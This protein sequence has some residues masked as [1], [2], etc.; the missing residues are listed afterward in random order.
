[1]YIGNLKVE[2]L[3]FTRPDSR[4][5]FEPTSADG[6][7]STWKWSVLYESAID[8]NITLA[9]S[10]FIGALTADITSGS[11]KKLEIFVDGVLCHTRAACALCGDTTLPVSAEGR[12]ITLRIH[13][14]VKDVTVGDIT[15]LGMY[16]DETP[17]IWPTPKSL[18]LKDGFVSVSG[19]SAAYGDADELAACAFLAD[20]LAETFADPY[21]ENGVPVTFIK[22]ASPEYEGERYTVDVSEDGIVITAASRLAL[23]YGADAL[24]QTDS[25]DGFPIMTID[26]KPVCSFRGFHIGL[27]AK[28]Q[29]EFV[30]RLLTYVLIPMRYN[31]LIVEFAGGMRFDRR[32]EITEAWLRA[33]ENEKKGLQ[34][35]MPH[36]GMVA[37]RG[38]LEKDDV[39][40]LVAFAKNLGIE[41]V[42]EV[43][44]FGH[45]Q[46]LTYAYP[47]VAE[48]VDADSD[49]KDERVED[50]RPVGFYPHCYCPSNPKSYE[51]I[52]DVIDE[53]VEVT[54]P[55]CVH[56]GHDE[57]YHIGLC[58]K[59]RTRKSD[60]LYA[61]DVNKLY[62]Y[63]TAKGKKVM[64]WS[65][66]LHDK[67][68][69]TKYTA[70]AIDR[71]PKDILM[72]DFT[73]YFHLDED[74]EAELTDHGFKVAIGN[75]YSSH[76]PRYN[77]RMS[78]EG[79]VG[80]QISCWVATNEKELA[81]N[82]KFWDAAVVGQMLWSPDMYDRRMFSTYSAVISSVI[83]PKMREG[84]RGIE[85]PYGCYDLSLG[86]RGDMP[87]AAVAAVCDAAVVSDAEFDIGMQCKTI[88]F[89]HATVNA[90]PR[91]PWEPLATV[92]TYT[93]NYEDG[94]TVAADIRYGGEI[95]RYDCSYA[96]PMPQQVY[97]H[98]G[99]VGTWYADPAIE[100]KAPDG[101]D[102]TICGFIWNNP[103]PEKKIK[104]I[105]YKDAD[106]SY[107]GLILE[108][109]NIIGVEQ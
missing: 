53:I 9:D 34:P 35:L 85:S 32:P 42:P 67:R 43:Q 106:G 19:V 93:I 8:V 22:L 48:L 41:F 95:M 102:V 70:P 29:I 20:R 38:V 21:D 62:D 10:C 51:I 44:S 50:A 3:T 49:V 52:F 12:E 109:I 89:N 37:E 58:P 64:M 18:E 105:S 98:Q 101:T 72:L 66:H 96:E 94:T 74:I 15:P 28:N 79:M 2:K 77:S 1:M 81:D 26:D 69:H 14:D 56:I 73:W 17:F 78:H 99:Y 30:K 57:I 63:I 84:I 24:M 108:S 25:L 31:T 86:V 4:L 90:M 46:W 33:D 47:D 71:I 11:V 60:D 83:Q 59:C 107:A 82:G 76:F 88:V 68:P 6:G 80:G 54:E 39:R 40:E 61:E 36:S 87:P 13:A 91:I 45:V 5:P 7:R 104:S 23:I 27:P 65:D 92:G 103:A 100:A 16:E 97:R 75:L 55:D